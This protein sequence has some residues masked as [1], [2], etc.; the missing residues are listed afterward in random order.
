MSVQT[1]LFQTWS[2]TQIVG[3]LK[4]SLISN[5]RFFLQFAQQIPQVMPVSVPVQ[6]LA[7]AAQQSGA[8]GTSVGVSGGSVVLL[9]P[10]SQQAQPG[11][12]HSPN[13]R[14]MVTQG[15]HRP[16]NVLKFDLCP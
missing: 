4:R 5:F 8:L 15:S 14:L 10:N 7:Y 1:G 2:G 13:S 16:G 9:Q 12:S 11:P 6:N 3:F